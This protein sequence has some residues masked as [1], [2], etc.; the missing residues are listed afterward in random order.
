VLPPAAEMEDPEV[1][2]WLG[3]VRP[4]DEEDEEAGR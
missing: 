2:G 4:D 3:L 1:A